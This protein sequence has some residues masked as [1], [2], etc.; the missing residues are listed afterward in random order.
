MIKRSNRKTH[1]GTD[2][3]LRS[4][5][6]LGFWAF[7]RP[8]PGGLPRPPPRIF[9]KS[10]LP[11]CP[12]AFP[13]LAPASSPGIS[14]LPIFRAFPGPS[15]GL[16]R[17]PRDFLVF[18]SSRLSPGLRRAYPVIFWSSGLLG[19]FELETFSPPGFSSLPVSRAFPGPSRGGLPR[20]PPLGIFWNASLP[21]F[22]Q[23]FPGLAPVPLLM[24]GPSPAAPT[25]LV[26]HNDKN[27]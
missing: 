9:W 18:R 13:R 5:S 11:G 4:F 14:G 22:L 27:R 2:L 10:G 19:N 26:K 23:A 7:P 16:P 3:K 25:I 17:P 6:P 15:R 8:S 21:G 1:F 24:P 20:P 12:R